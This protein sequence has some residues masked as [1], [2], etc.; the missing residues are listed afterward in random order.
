MKK[1]SETE[2]IF[3]P[4]TV[5]EERKIVSNDDPF[6]MQTKEYLKP[7][8]W[9]AINYFKLPEKIQTDLFWE[10]VNDVPVAAQRFLEHNGL[11]KDYKFSAYFG[12]YIGQRINKIKHLKRKK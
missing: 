2:K 10:L 11:K 1:K 8:I 4:K 5:K 12:W 3:I 7:L 9:T 6:F